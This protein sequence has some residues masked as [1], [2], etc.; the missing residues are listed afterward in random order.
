M[1]KKYPAIALIE[2][3]SIAA[4]I[5]CADAM[6]KKAPITVI[7]S[8]TVHNGKYLILIGGSVAS[9]EEAYY[10]GLSKTGDA[11][12]D[13]VILPD[14][15]EQVHDAILG[16]RAVCS[17]AAIG[18]IETSSVAATIQSADAAIKGTDINIIEIRLA[19]DLG[20]KAFT[21]F[22]GD[23]EDIQAAVTIAEEKTTSQTFWISK[24]VIPNL[25]SDMANQI[26]SSTHFS[27]L[28]MHL[29]EEGE[30]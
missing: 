26:E 16:H 28:N 11:K 15:H 10:E 19:N 30:V 14:V 22:N 27:K 29:L 9:V 2:L 1:M 20:G 6:V 17:K 7:K 13:K 5:L 25:H 8:G 23:I 3:S 21:I 12:I 18:I 24:T 4:G